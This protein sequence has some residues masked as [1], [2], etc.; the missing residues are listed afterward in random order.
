[1]SREQFETFA[2]DYESNFTRNEDDAGDEYANC[3]LQV[4]WETWQAC[5]LSLKQQ[6]AELLETMSH[7]IAADKTHYEYTDRHSKN[8]A[9]D[10]PKAGRRWATPRELAQAAI[11]KAGEVK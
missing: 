5:E 7:I 4:M 3:T 6:N 9:G 8:A 2:A 11:T 1:M 10:K